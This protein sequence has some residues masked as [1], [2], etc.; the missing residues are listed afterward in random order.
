MVEGGKMSVF[1]RG[2]VI[3]NWECKG[4]V[5]SACNNANEARNMFVF[6]VVRVGVYMARV[7][8]A[9][10]LFFDDVSEDLYRPTS[11]LKGR[12]LREI[13]EMII[14]PL[15]HQPGFFTSCHEREAFTRA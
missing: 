10:R 14:R 1:G 13:A 8:S 6:K 2:D 15:I 12:A 11:W 3:T 7:R 9:S 5:S 4:A